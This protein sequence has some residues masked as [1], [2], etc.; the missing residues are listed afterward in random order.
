MNFMGSIALWLQKI[1]A[2][3]RIE[4]RSTLCRLV[5]TQFT[6]DKYQRYH[7]QLCALKQTSSVQEYTDKFLH[8]RLNSQRLAL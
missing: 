8:I 2:D 1:E 4:D 6:R 5:D 3:G 7:R